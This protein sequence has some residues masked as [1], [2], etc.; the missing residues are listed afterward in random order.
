MHRAA[1]KAG[2]WYAGDH[3]GL[4]LD[5]EECLAAARDRY[6]AAVTEAAGVPAG[7]MTP[8]AGLFFSGA[9]AAA[10]FELV[11]QRLGKVDVFVVFGACHRAN[12]REP[13]VWATG[14]WDTPLGSV[15]VDEDFARAL[16]AS[17]LGREDYR[18]HE[19]DNAIELQMPFIKFLFPDAKIVPV[20][21]GFFPDA[22]D[23]G[24][25]AAEAAKARGGTVAAVASTD[26]T[27][28]GSAF[29]VMPA[30]TGASALAWIRDNDQRFLDAAMSLDSR[31]IVEIAQREHSA[32]GAG[33]VA[34]LA[35]WAE[36]FGCKRGRL[37]AYANSH[38]VMPRGE[39]D[40]VVGYGAVAYEV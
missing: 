13:A 24:R 37:L 8:H 38:E 2:S 35:G 32:C 10:A 15:E 34:A 28:Y 22:G 7:V 40:H 6:G 4:I 14:R 18:A 25:L 39:A 29:G 21:M 5:V 23:M 17:G 20:A 27:H 16:I 3:D 11:R 9:V 12:L 33:A 31:L 1:E 36:A 26:L 30:G 19:G